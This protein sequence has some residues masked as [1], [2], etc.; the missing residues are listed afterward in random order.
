MT[1]ECSPDFFDVTGV[2][3]W[4]EDETL[5]SL[6]SRFHHLSC[7]MTAGATLSML[8][9]SAQRGYQHDLPAGITAFS[10]ATRGRHGTAHSIIQ[11]HTLLPYYLPFRTSHDA[12]NAYAAMAGPSIGSLKY[13]LGILTSR[14]RAH[15]PLKACTTCML[16]DLEKCSVA[17]WHLS[18][19]YPGVWLCLK[20]HQRLL[21]CTLKSTGVSRFQW[22]LPHKDNL[23]HVSN[24]DGTISDNVLSLLQS[25]AHAA[26]SLSQLP[27]DFHFDAIRLLNVYHAKLKHHEFITHGGRLRLEEIAQS[28]IQTIRLPQSID[29]FSAFATTK[30]DAK[31]QIGK[32]LRLPRAGTHPLRHLTLIL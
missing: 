23:M 32:L 28:Y 4:L 20:H 21:T 15:H 7:N 10:Q 8:F 18:H 26:I 9:G 19:Q 2:P 16:E 13:R 25:L 31:Q 17:Y 1:R 3:D 14:F 6:T 5:F 11:R 12:V 27:K 29:E 24:D 22:V 30:S